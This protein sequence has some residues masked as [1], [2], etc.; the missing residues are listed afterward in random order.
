MSNARQTYR[1]IETLSKSRGW[2]ILREAMERDILAAA[3]GLGS[4]AEMPEAEMHFRRGA[5]FAA[6]QLLRLPQNILAQLE[7]DVRIEESRDDRSPKT[8]EGDRT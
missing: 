7:A 5:I 8:L 1:A 6:D 2:A 4:R 3:K